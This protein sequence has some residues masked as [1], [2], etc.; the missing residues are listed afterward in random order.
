MTPQPEWLVRIVECFSTETDALLDE[1]ILP[2][3][4][5]SSLQEVWGRPTTDPMVECYEIGHEQ[6]AF[7]SRVVGLEFDLARFS[8]FLSAYTTDWEAT[9]QAGGFMGLYPPPKDLTGLP[10]L[11]K[12]KPKTKG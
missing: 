1:V 5:L 11:V 9:K 3:I 8:Y 12:V 10:D 2:P 4:E 7:L 6:A